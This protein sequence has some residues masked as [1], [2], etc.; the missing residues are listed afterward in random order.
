[1][2]APWL[3]MTVQ[4]V[5]AAARSSSA[6]A[7][8]GS[9]PFSSN[10]GATSTGRPVASASGASVCTQRRGEADSNRSGP[11][12]RSSRQSASACD[13]PMPHSGRS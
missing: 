12:D 3:Q 10:A 7:A 1:M 11:Q 8:G 6:V 5:L 4:P 9:A 2:T 13:S